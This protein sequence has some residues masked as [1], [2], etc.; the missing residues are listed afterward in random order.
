MPEQV[1]MSVFQISVSVRVVIELRTAAPIDDIVSRI[2]LKLQNHPPVNPALQQRPGGFRHRRKG[3]YAL[4]RC[5]KRCKQFRVT[6]RAPLFEKLSGC[7]HSNWVEA[8]SG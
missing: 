1:Q 6:A 5:P 7:G 3:S 2:V 4:P 8:S